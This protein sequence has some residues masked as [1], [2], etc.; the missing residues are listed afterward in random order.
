[1][2]SLAQGHTSK[3]SQRVGMRGRGAAIWFQGL[4]SQSLP[5]TAS[6][7][8]LVSHIWCLTKDSGSFQP[9]FLHSFLQ[10]YVGL[11]FCP[12][13]GLSYAFSSCITLHSWSFFR[14]SFSQSD[15]Q[16]G[17]AVQGTQE[18]SLLMGL[19]LDQVWKIVSDSITS[20]D[21][22]FFAL[23]WRRGTTAKKKKKK[24]RFL[25]SNSTILKNKISDKNSLA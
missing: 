24:S 25:T 12:W 4:R 6:E 7:H 8:P 21:L 3:H 11:H 15:R 23:D 13:W 18:L 9:R 22:D 20:S 5:F 10:L 19:S 2:K 16:P 1:M 17:N 14:K